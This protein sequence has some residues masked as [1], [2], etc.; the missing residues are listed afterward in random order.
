MKI[1]YERGGPSQWSATLN[2]K[3]IGQ[4]RVITYHREEESEY[5]FHVKDLTQPPPEVMEGE[6]E[7]E[8]VCIP[9]SPCASVN[10]AKAALEYHFRNLTEA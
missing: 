4:I 7:P 3:V 9:G 5:H 10:Q 8:P 6:D 2:G 1:E